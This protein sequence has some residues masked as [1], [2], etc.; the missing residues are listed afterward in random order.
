MP[1]STL[2]QTFINLIE[3]YSNSDEILSRLE[4]KLVNKLE[5][6]QQKSFSQKDIVALVNVVLHAI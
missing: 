6:Y 3:N 5:R 4:Y 2:I 1:T